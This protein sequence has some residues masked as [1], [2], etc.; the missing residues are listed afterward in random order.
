MLAP[1]AAPDYELA[2]ADR[3]LGPHIDLGDA[4]SGWRLRFQFTD[5]SLETRIRAL[6]MDFN[7]L[8]GV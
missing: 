4:G 5:K 1:G 2:R 6:E 8:F 3:L 7:S